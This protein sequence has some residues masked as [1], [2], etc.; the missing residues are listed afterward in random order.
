MCPVTF[1]AIQFYISAFLN[2]D[3]KDLS[4]CFKFGPR[5]FHIRR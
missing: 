1:P 4:I 2:S 3:R 5:R